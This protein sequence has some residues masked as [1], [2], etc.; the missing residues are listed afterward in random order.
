MVPAESLLVA[1]RADDG[2]LTGL[3]EQ[4]DSVLLSLRGL[5]V[6][7][8][9]HS[10]GAMIEVGGQHYFSSIG[11]EDG[12][13]PCGSVRG[14]SQA[15]EDRWDLYD[16]SPDVFVESIEDAWLKSLEDHVIGTLDLTVSTWMSDQG[17]LDPDAVSITEIQELLPGEVSFVVS[18]DIVRNTKT[19]NDVKEELDHLFRANVGDGLRL[20]P[21]GEFVHRYE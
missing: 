16:P 7:K 12:C 19:V 1:S 20:Y 3:L 14:H 9:F 6:I 2:R 21:L 18:D 8:S 17:P 10:W 5:I 11:Q 13:E 4:V 15:L